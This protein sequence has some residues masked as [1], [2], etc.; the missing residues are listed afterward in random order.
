MPL[1]YPWDTVMGHIRAFWW[2]LYMLDILGVEVREAGELCLVEVH[3]EQ[4]VG[5]SEVGAFGGEL[6][7]EVAHVLTMSLWGERQL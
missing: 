5:G 4:L 3:E 7:V 6:L 1:V 2:C